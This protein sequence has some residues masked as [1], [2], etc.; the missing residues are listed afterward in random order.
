[1]WARRFT[2]DPL[3]WKKFC[4]RMPAKLYIIRHGETVSNVAQVYQGAGDSPLTDNG[5]LMAEELAEDLEDLDFKGIYC[6]DLSRAL[7]TAEIISRF[8]PV[9]PKIMEDLRERS[10]GEWE[11]LSFKQIAEQYVDVYREWM[12]NPANA[13]I[14]GAESLDDLQMRAIR[15]LRHILEKH[16]DPTHNICIV[17]HGGINR[18][19]LF[20]FMGLG[21]NHFWRIR[22]SN[23]CI[24]VVEFGKYPVVSLLN[25]TAHIKQAKVGRLPIY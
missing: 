3:I 21:L 11:G 5:I 7:K 14:P 9:D 22:Q 24:N 15:S 10:Y 8:H 20:Y 19:L 1:M 18:A 17:G 23:S 13:K 12:E 2:P 6:S 4:K 25:C 16:Q